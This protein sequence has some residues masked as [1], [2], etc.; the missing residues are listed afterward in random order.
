MKAL[1]LQFLTAVLD[2]TSGVSLLREFL[3]RLATQGI[4]IDVTLDTEIGV[5]LEDLNP[6]KTAKS[7][8]ESRGIKLL[9]ALAAAG[10]I[11][12]HSVNTSR[13]SDNFGVVTV[14]DCRPT[15]NPPLSSNEIG[16]YSTGLITSHAVN[17]TD[18]FWNL[19]EK[20]YAAFTKSKKTNKH[21]TDMALINYLMCK[22]IDN[23]A[24]TPSSSQ[25]TSLLSAVLNNDCW[26]AQVGL[27]DFVSCASG[28]GV[29]PSITITDTVHEGQLKCTLSYPAPLHSREQIVE[30]VDK[31]K[32]ILIDATD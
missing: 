8:C 6:K 9:G 24:L 12:A 10:M 15:L 16:F 4:D 3:A 11:A 27:E 1:A 23:P 21:F 18:T 19:A 25:R 31:M 32:S 7:G 2:R 20:T 5:A 26:M 22:A 29:G 30:I 28:H 13:N 14:F 17:K